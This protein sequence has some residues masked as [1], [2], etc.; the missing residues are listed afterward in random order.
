MAASNRPELN[1]LDA[2]KL[3]AEYLR[4]CDEG[5]DISREE[6]LGRHERLL[7]EL[8]IEFQKVDSLQAA[9]SPTLSPNHPD[10]ELHRQT[11]SNATI[12]RCPHCNHPNDVAL[13]ATLSTLNVYRCDHCQAEFQLLRERQWPERINHFQLIERIGSGGFG[14]VWKALHSEL[15]RYVALKLPRTSHLQGSEAEQFLQ[16]ARTAAS[17]DHPGIVKVY[18]I[19]TFEDNIYIASEFIEGK[20]LAERIGKGL[21]QNEAVSIALQLAHALDYAHQAQVVHR[22]VKPHNVL[23]DATGKP[24]LS[25]FGLAGHFTTDRTVTL[26]ATGEVFGTPSYM[27]PE[28]A[29]GQRVDE[30]S[31]VY[32]L[33]VVLYEMLTGQV[34]FQ[35]TVV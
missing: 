8:Y 24:H 18:E 1:Q 17:L 13:A 32:S 9:L 22:D 31:D 2:R 16:E 23:L 33:G 20:S 26:D 27:S 5:V 6:I 21:S 14:T 11:Q 19:G 3:V 34:P 15:G 25:D 12:V 7:Q 35:G 10:A 4:L 28:Q 30:R 29:R